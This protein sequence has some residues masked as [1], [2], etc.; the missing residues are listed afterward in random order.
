MSLD[1]E[2]EKGEVGRVVES[3]MKVLSL[4]KAL[5]QVILRK[6]KPDSLM[7]NFSISNLTKSTAADQL[8]NQKNLILLNGPRPTPTRPIAHTHTH[9][10]AIGKKTRYDI[11]I[12][13]RIVKNLQ[14]NKQ[15]HD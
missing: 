14:T 8:P 12:V 1:K 3:G 2:K 4:A 9:T 10:D 6:D 15:I 13:V 11:R 5:C 7:L